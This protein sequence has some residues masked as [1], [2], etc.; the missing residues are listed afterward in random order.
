MFELSIST[1]SDKQHYIN[2]IFD[3]LKDELKADKGVGVKYN[4]G[5]RSYY[6]I[7]VLEKKKEYYKSKIVDHIV[8]MI[9]D[10]YKFN[11]FKENLLFTNQ[12]IISQS[13]LKAI[14]IFDFQMDGEI[15]KS[16][17]ELTKDV[18]VDSLYYFKLG[19][20][21]EKWKKTA[22]IINQNHILCSSES[23]IEVLKYLTMSS[24][25]NVITADICIEK[26]QIKFKNVLKC[27]CFKKNFEGY[28]NFL[29]EMV[30]LNP[31]KI[32][33]KTNNYDDSDKIVQLLNQIFTDK[34]YL[35]N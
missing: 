3:K 30:K 4:Y 35:L 5:G 13:F 14:S 7:A 22:F 26:K 10:D 34:I 1:T 11:Y 16:Q 12:N 29:T 27:Q 32:N 17:I 24:E 9:I 19:P 25:H 28:S 33:L 18:L 31:V 23:M 20:L 21:L 2:D 15:I 8:F 6:S